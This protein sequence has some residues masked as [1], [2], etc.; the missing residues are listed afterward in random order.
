MVGERELV[1]IVQGE[2]NL[3]KTSDLVYDCFDTLKPTYYFSADGKQVDYI[4]HAEFIASHSFKAYDDGV[5]WVYPMLTFEDR[6][7]YNAV[8]LRI[9]YYERKLIDA[10]RAEVK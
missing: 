1:G 9:T 10:P 2:D 7:A 4:T 5:Y 3:G 8:T 6:G